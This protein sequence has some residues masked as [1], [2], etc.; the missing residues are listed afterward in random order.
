[1][2]VSLKSPTFSGLQSLNPTSKMPPSPAITTGPDALSIRFGNTQSA[3]ASEGKENFFKRTGSK[4]KN[5]FTIEDF[6]F[7]K[8]AKGAGQGVLSYFT[9]PKKGIFLD[10]GINAGIGVALAGVLLATGLGAAAIP[11]L[12]PILGVTMAIFSTVQMTFRAIKGFFKPEFYAAQQDELKKD[13]T[14]TA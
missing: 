9:S 3:D 1:M 11:S 10:L 6:S 13:E 5:F 14:S 7:K 8:S 4:I 2:D 12:L